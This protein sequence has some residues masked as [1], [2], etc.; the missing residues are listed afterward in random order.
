MTT[1]I[2]AYPIGGIGA[3]AEDFTAFL[4]AR[5]AEYWPGYG[6]SIELESRALPKVY[7]DA[8]SVK[9]LTQADL[10]ILE[11]VRHYTS[12]AAWDDFKSNNSDALPLLTGT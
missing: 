9:Q 4:Q 11:E 12:M 7:F 8:S 5:T 3:Q 10:G 1:F 2:I 6:F